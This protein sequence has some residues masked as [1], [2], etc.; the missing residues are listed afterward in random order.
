MLHV[1][2]FNS[3][4][5]AWQNAF[6]LWCSLVIMR[7]LLYYKYV[8]IVD[9]DA[10]RDEHLQLLRSLNL[11]GKVFVAR[12]GINGC[13]TG[14]EQDAENYKAA[15]RTDSRFADLEFKDT[16][17]SEHGFRKTIVRVRPEIVTSSTTV[18][19]TN[20][21]PYI[22]ANELKALLESGE[23]VIL[24]DA[25]NNY[26][27]AIGRFK[28]AITPDISVFRK[29][30]DVAD[31]LS[32]LKN[33]KIVTY[34]TGGIRCEKASAVLKERG[35]TDVQQ[36]HGGII[37]YGEEVGNDHW[38]GRCFVFDT[39]GSIAIHPEG[40]SE[41]IASC[42]DCH[43]PADTYYNCRRVLC[44]KRL[45]GCSKCIERLQGFC[46]RFCLNEHAR[47]E[48]EAQQRACGTQA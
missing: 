21:A 48:R 22:E 42:H 17:A 16:P 9:P 11:K 24:L 8:E 18:N 37:R 44:D 46:S 35:F 38:E 5:R 27:S 28:N 23:E 14:A 7:N 10:F 6:N 1:T 32:K 4:V 39:R 41:P 13:I 34:C 26:E 40:Q 15:M 47:R 30:T 43:L 25:R 31:E 12:E 19:L 2:V 29:F 20:A 3:L 33:K 36:L 45:I